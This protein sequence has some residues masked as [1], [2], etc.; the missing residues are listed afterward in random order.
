MNFYSYFYKPE[1]GKETQEKQSVFHSAEERK[2]KKEGQK[3]RGKEGGRGEKG[4]EEA[5]N[6]EEK[7]EDEYRNTKNERK[8]LFSPII[9]TNENPLILQN[10]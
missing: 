1:G 6:Q 10:S 7:K 4:R 3:K 8:V 2:E 9:A 5:E